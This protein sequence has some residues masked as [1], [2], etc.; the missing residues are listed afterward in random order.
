MKARPPP[1]HSAGDD[2]HFAATTSSRRSPGQRS[3]PAQLTYKS[4]AAAA[5]SCR[6]QA[7]TT[8]MTRARDSYLPVDV[9]HL[10][11]RLQSSSYRPTSVLS[12]SV[13]DK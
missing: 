7:M 13:G 6:G 2:R 3:R 9:T 4:R 8:P 12:S 1:R 11:P 5:A 10:A